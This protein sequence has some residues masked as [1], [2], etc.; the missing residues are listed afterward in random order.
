MVPDPNEARNVVGLGF[1]PDNATRGGRGGSE[2]HA[3]FATGDGDESRHF[4][5]FASTDDDDTI[6]ENSTGS[7][8]AVYPPSSSTVISHSSLPVGAA[9]TVDVTA[10][11]ERH[12]ILALKHGL[13]TD[14]AEGGFDCIEEI[15]ELIDRA[16]MT[17]LFRP[18]ES[19][20]VGGIHA[21]PAAI[22]RAIRKLVPSYDVGTTSKVEVDALLAMREWTRSD[23]AKRVL[24]S[25]GA[26]HDG[27]ANETEEDSA[28]NQSDIYRAFATKT[29]SR[30]R[31]A[32][33]ECKID[34]AREMENEDVRRAE[35][36][37][38][39]WIKLL[40]AVTDDEEATRREVLC[41]ASTSS[42]SSAAAHP[43]DTPTEVAVTVRGGLTS[44]VVARH[45]S[46]AINTVCAQLD[47]LSV[48]VLRHIQTSANN[49]LSERL[50]NDIHRITGTVAKAG[51]VMSKLDQDIVDSLAFLGSSSM[52]AIGSRSHPSGYSY[53][54][55]TTGDTTA[56]STLIA[57]VTS[58]LDALSA[59][60]ITL[61]LSPSSAGDSVTVR[62]FLLGGGDTS[63]ASGLS[64]PSTES[65]EM[66]AAVAGASYLAKLHIDSVRELCLARCLLVLG[67]DRLV[68]AAA[69]S[70]KVATAMMGRTADT[71]IGGGGGT[72]VMSGSIPNEELV[73]DALCAYLRATA[74]QFAQAQKLDA[75]SSP[76]T[77]SRDDV[78]SSSRPRVSGTLNSSEASPG[79]EDFSVVEAVCLAIDESLRESSGDGALVS[80]AVG[81]GKQFISMTS[82]AAGDHAGSSVNQISML[83]PFMNQDRIALRLLAPDVAYPEVY[84]AY[85]ARQR[86]AEAASE[87]LLTEATF[88]EQ[89]NTMSAERILSLRERASE[90]LRSSCSSVDT[91]VDLTTVCN[92]LKKLHDLTKD[93]AITTTVNLEDLMQQI[94][95]QPIPETVTS[96]GIKALCSMQATRGL[97]LP[98]LEQAS[99]G[100]NMW[101]LIE[102]H[103]PPD[104]VSDV[105]AD[106]TTLCQALLCISDLIQRV[107]VLERHC[108]NASGSCVVLRAIKDVITAIDELIPRAMAEEYMPEYPTL[109]SSA[110]QNAMLERNWDEAYAACVANPMKERRVACFRR[111]VIGMA[112][113]GAVQELIEMP[114]TVIGK[115][116][117]PNADVTM[118]SDDD[119]VEPAIEK[120]SVDEIDLYEL[121]AETL[122]DAALEQNRNSS[123]LRAD[124]RGCLYS[125]HASRANWR[126]ASAA[127]AFGGSLARLK[128]ATSN[129]D[130]SAEEN[131]AIIDAITLAALGA[132]H[133][134]QL[135]D[136]PSHRFLVPNELG[137]YP[138]TPLLCEG[139]DNAA[140]LTGSNKRGRDGHRQL[141]FF[142]QDQ[143]QHS[144]STVNRSAL[145]LR[146][147]DLIAQAI[148]SVGLRTSL[149]DQSSADASVLKA[150]RATSIEVAEELA[151][152]GYYSLALGLAKTVYDK[153][154]GARPKGRDL[155]ISAVAYI[156]LR[157]VVP[158]AIRCSRPTPT[159]A[160]EGSEWETRIDEKDIMR[161]TLAQ[162]HSSVENIDPRIQTA[163]SN[164]TDGWKSQDK[165]LTS[166]H[167]A[168]CMDLLRTYTTTYANSTNKLAVDVAD[169]LLD[170]DNCMATLPI[171]LTD[172]LCGTSS[173][174]FADVAKETSESDAADPTALVKLYMKH[175]L[176]AQAC[177]VVARALDK[178]GKEGSSAAR[179]LP[180]EG[181][182]DFVPYSTI[183]QLWNI[184]ESAAPG[185]Q[186]DEKCGV[187]QARADMEVALEEHMKRIRI[188]EDGLVSA[189]ALK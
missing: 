9:S 189:R 72:G 29:P 38:S 136:N 125:L 103:Y 88:A 177:K 158:T 39:R 150:L 163:P 86:T 126:R 159:N 167:G 148:E 50:C 107:K 171:W 119:E 105:E 49:H 182:I 143:S 144:T 183:D 84:V 58:L 83:G 118:T 32:G 69:E 114:L 133:A 40:L 110:F 140:N 157:H 31:G 188:S 104:F 1:A 115:P 41:L 93:Y 48:N 80:S 109:I 14:I 21:N 128:A 79:I 77:T 66:S 44:A 135:E 132:A 3:L 180:E 156:I 13:K 121:A 99:L 139:M 120:S 43:C 57:T 149:L 185:M 161:P 127:I 184:I 165:Q 54:P 17:K 8:F 137:Q 4:H 123:A 162:I 16:C 63:S 87:C 181:Q 153:R 145:L 94:L 95:H 134:I 90:I 116:T 18:T 75:P 46:T 164:C 97:F 47:A 152:Q 42:M 91:L 176:Y 98:L 146:E 169:T 131:R 85:E 129:S 27:N 100:G 6:A 37:L 12:S 178:T 68:S 60:E 78:P 151:S 52:K 81:V 64:I 174:C 130:L 168:A 106:V 74:V 36:H 173:G 30:S 172:L 67:T 166:A 71:I 15:T 96:K 34:E 124:Y 62:S 108:S 11:A 56:S 53:N 20:S 160:C 142:V 65:S 73:N 186:P 26:G 89:N 25:V 175:G 117:G 61:W 51:L 28:I 19:R 70:S 154:N 138:A 59:E 92:A 10:Q 2:L 45:S 102:Q 33:E 179:R 5:T 170:L 141:P 35:A 22:R 155:F 55:S 122:A 23:E 112:D 76:S 101:S 147:T 187:M 111:L 24:L 113:A 7:I 82:N